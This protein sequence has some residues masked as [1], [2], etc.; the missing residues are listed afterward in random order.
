MI[1]SKQNVPGPLQK[2]MLYATS[3][4]L[5]VSGTIWLFFRYFIQGKGDFNSPSYAEQATCLRIHGAAAIVFLIVFGA[6]LY[7]ILPGWRQ[8]YQ[9]PSGLSLIV[10]CVFLIITGWGLYYM[11]N[12]YYRNLVSVIHSILGFL[13]PA[14]IFFHVFSAYVYRKQ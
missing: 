4:L 1:Q 5:W 10:T 13:L 9:R 7:H 11:G 6:L 14:I 12:E 3:A 8:K 2:K